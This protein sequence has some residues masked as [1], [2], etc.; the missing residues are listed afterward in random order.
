MKI[1]LAFCIL[2]CLP[3]VMMAQFIYKPGFIINNSN[4]TTKGFLKEDEETKLYKSVLFATSET[5][6]GEKVFSVTDIKGFSFT[7]A[8][9][10]QKVHYI[11]ING[12]EVSLFAH[13]LVSGYFKLFS[14][15]TDSR[16]FYLVKNSE[17]STYLLYD[18]ETTTMGFLETPGNY[19]NQLLFL[20]LSCGNLRERLYSIQYTTGD[21]IDFIQ[22]VNK[23]KSPNTYSQ[24]LYKKPESTL[25][26]YAYA[27]GIILGKNENE[28]TGRI[29]GR[30]IIPTVSQNTSLNFGVNYMNYN[31]VS[32]RE[33]TLDEPFNNEAVRNERITEVPFSIQY[34]LFRGIIQPYVNAGV[35][36]DYE[37]T[38]GGFDGQGFKAK[39]AN[40]FG[41]GLVAS[42]GIECPLTPNLYIKAD[43]TY[44][45]IMHHP[46]IG[47]AYFFK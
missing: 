41:V 42:A 17:D 38:S 35:S 1:A 30:I 20:S 32:R 8:N 15:K 27:G 46:V 36:L 4:D 31:T 25:R 45:L 29:M 9:T 3:A 40:K 37:Q 34:I 28:I 26:F 22:S 11:D 7:G 19:K 10:Y 18:D 12:A 6:A 23:C 5:G 44:E 39:P 2:L 16:L 43:L 13:V 47:I 21:M 14:F 24:V 33:P